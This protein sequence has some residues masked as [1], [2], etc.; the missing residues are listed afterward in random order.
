M[1]QPSPHISLNSSRLIRTLAELDVLGEAYS[2]KDFGRR[3]GQLFTLTDSLGL[4][5][6]HYELTK[7]P[8]EA[9]EK[10]AVEIIDTFIQQRQALIAGLSVNFL[11][12]EQYHQVRNRFP[13]F[14]DN[15]SPD[16]VSHFDAY[17]RFYTALQRQISF[18]VQH[19]QS[20]VRD[21]AAGLS[22]ELAKLVLLDSTLGDTLN[23]HARKLF[24]LVPKLLGTRFE[25]LRQQHDQTLFKPEQ[26]EPAHWIN[27]GGWLDQFRHDCHNLL[28]AELDIR[29]QPVLGLIEAIEEHQ[30]QS[31]TATTDRTQHD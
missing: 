26:D 9:R 7:L 13:A 11:G 27:A 15:L 6:M 4:S 19:I 3:F 30:Q 22:P 21:G 29:L 23:N 12:G 28:L 2:A 17:L 31:Q 14:R 10:P 20:T 24:P 16:Q 18:D 8:F 1:S 5:D 25:W